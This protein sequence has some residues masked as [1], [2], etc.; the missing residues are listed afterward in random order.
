MKSYNLSVTGTPRTTAPFRANV[1]AS[2]SN[3]LY[4]SRLLG[5][6]GAKR[7]KAR[8]VLEV[9]NYPE[10][11]IGAVFNIDVAVVIDSNAIVFTFECIDN[12]HG[13]DTDICSHS[14]SP[15][16]IRNLLIRNDNCR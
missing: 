11:I 4:S 3:I 2:L 6:S 15:Q 14:T 16:P 13:S 10:R 7:K 8:G 1:L 5:T 9:E 12:C